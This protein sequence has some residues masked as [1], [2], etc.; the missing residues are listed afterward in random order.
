[1]ATR[2]QFS[3]ASQAAIQAKSPDTLVTTGVTFAFSGGH[4][5]LVLQNTVTNATALVTITSAEDEHGRKA[6]ASGAL[7][8]PVTLASAASA[9]LG[10]QCVPMRNEAWADANG[11]INLAGAA[12]VNAWF[13]DTP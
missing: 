2:I 5:L 12:T 9:G 8:V 1:M 10:Y 3:E 6:G 13:I 4:G 7:T 11:Y